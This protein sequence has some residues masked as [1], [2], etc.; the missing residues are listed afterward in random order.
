MEMENKIL[1]QDVCKFA[2]DVYES[3]VPDSTEQKG[4]LRVL[5]GPLAEW[6]KLNRNKR[7]YSEKLWD[8]VLESSYVKEQIAYKTLY[9]EMNHPED[10]MEVD[11]GR[12]SHSISKLWKVPEKQQIYGEINILDTPYG[13]IL[14]TLYE[15]GGI[16]GYSSRAGGTLKQQKDYVEVEERSYS[17]VTFDAVPFPSVQSARPDEIVEGVG[18]EE[19]LSED[20]HNS[21]ISI[22]KESSAK[23]Y[24]NIKSLIYSIKGFD[25]TPEKQIF[26]G[27]ESTFNDTEEL[28]EIGGDAIEANTNDSEHDSEVDDL[29]C[30]LQHMTAQKTSLEKE[31]AGLRASLSDTLKK[32]SDI[33][34]ATGKNDNQLSNEIDNLEYAIEEKDKLISDLESEIEMLRDELEDLSTVAEACKALQYKNQSLISESSVTPCN[35]EEINQKYQK[36]LAFVV[37]KLDIANKEVEDMAGELSDSIIEINKGRRIISYQQDAIEELQREL[38]D[39]MQYE[40]SLHDKLENSIMA[41]KLMEGTKEELSEKDNE[42]SKLRGEIEDLRKELKAVED[43]LNSA[44]ESYTELKSVNRQ[45]KNDLISSISGNY[46]LTVEDVKKKLPVGFT[47]SDIFSVCEGMVNTTKKGNIDILSINTTSSQNNKPSKVRDLF[48]SNRRG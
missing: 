21:L 29:L 42:I 19:K 31:N 35:F 34:N 24:E 12:V 11:F 22:I 17:F 40:V 30:K 4:I 33:M 10:R 47:K 1:L 8:D 48:N 43:K 2:G 7:K 41:N 13:R 16:I 46:G 15:A 39:R 3:S 36:D 45:F 44:N 14:N 18:Y 20:V 5:R 28:A 26:E 32:F 27:T 23:D 6:D 37:D 9:G 38:Q 25:L